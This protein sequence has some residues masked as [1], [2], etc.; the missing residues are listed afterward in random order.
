MISPLKAPEACFYKRWYSK[1]VVFIMKHSIRCRGD[2][3][4]VPN[5]S[6]DPFSIGAY[7]FNST[8]YI[9]K[10]HKYFRMSALF[11]TGVTDCS[12]RKWTTFCASLQELLR[13]LT[14]DCQKITTVTILCFMYILS[15]CMVLLCRPNAINRTS[16][17]MT[18]LWSRVI[19]T[20]RL[21]RMQ[22]T[23]C[24]LRHFSVRFLLTFAATQP[25]II[26]R[27]RCICI[28]TASQIYE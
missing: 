19:R 9:A 28:M 6:L 1:W 11:T 16:H 13:F 21:K 25:R 27:A 22:I 23:I 20:S 7:I 4:P 3:F 12:V 14:T 10:A 26:C 2:Y 17:L 15:T 8:N 24:H 18:L 5:C